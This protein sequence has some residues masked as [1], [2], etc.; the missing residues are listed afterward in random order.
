M[1]PARRAR[2]VGAQG[3]WSLASAESRTRSPARGA[4]ARANFRPAAMRSRPAPARAASSLLDAVVDAEQ[5]QVH[6][7]HD[8]ADDA[9]DEDDHDRLEDRGQ[10]LDG[11]LDL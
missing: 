7:D 1:T 3:S 5:R 8:H 11:S 4:A 9:A 2:P 10:G 6:R